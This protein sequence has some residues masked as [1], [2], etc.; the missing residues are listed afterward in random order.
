MK[1]NFS[2]ILLLLTF[3]ACT[4]K[5]ESAETAPEQ[6]KTATEIPADTIRKSIPKEVKDKIGDA[7]VTITYHAPAV[8]GRT[9]WGGLV[10]Y[11]EVW[12]TGA[13]KATTFEIDKSFEF[14]SKRIDAGK[15]GFFTIPAENNWTIILNKNWDQHLTDE[16]DEKDDVIRFQVPAEEGM[17]LQERLYYDIVDY[18]GSKGGVVI[19]WEKIKVVVPIHVK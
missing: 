7:N 16:Y 5:K 6:P 17:D 10:P 9:I 18:E 3:V 11:G 13:H 14:G 1:I 15:Y 12:V 19:R 2:I 4:Q 8:R